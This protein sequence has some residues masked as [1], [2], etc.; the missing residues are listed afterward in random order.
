MAKNISDSDIAAM[1]S[2]FF[3]KVKS[4]EMRSQILT[5]ADAFASE[6]DE[7]HAS[8]MMAWYLAQPEN[9]DKIA[10]LASDYLGYAPDGV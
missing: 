1:R 8:V 5:I 9:Q 10:E 7:E 6:S 3:E 4:P 2:E